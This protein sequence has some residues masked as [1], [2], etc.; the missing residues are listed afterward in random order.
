[1][2]VRHPVH[3]QRELVN[4]GLLATEIEDPDFRIRHT[5]VEP[6]FGVRLSTRQYVNRYHLLS[7]FPSTISPDR[8]AISGKQRA[9]RMFMLLTIHPHNT[10]MKTLRIIKIG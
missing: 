2:L 9:F 4:I 1:M 6:G 8:V 5:T 10:A 7:Y 3:A